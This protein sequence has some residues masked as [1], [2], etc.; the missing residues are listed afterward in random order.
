MS[1]ERVRE[2]SE[3]A[4]KENLFRK[5][6]EVEIGGVKYVIRRPTRAEM[7][8][9]GINF[10]LSL[11][12]RLEDKIVE[13]N[14]AEKRVKLIEEREKAQYELE[15]RLLLICVQDMTE[16][17]LDKLEYGEWYK[18]FSEVNEFVFIIPFQELLNQRRSREGSTLAT[19]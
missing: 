6:K 4:S 18:L 1:V 10:L 14:D 15:K 2:Y 9:S 13:E 17:K 19:L 8:N 12:S 11:I 3:I 7:F 16:E 5:M